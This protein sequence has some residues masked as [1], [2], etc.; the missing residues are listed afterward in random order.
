MIRTNGA[1][2]RFEPRA[3][4]E[5]P[6][7]L[8]RRL[9]GGRPKIVGIIQARTGSTRLPGKILLPILGRPV[10]S[11]MLERVAA[12]REL[13]E[14]VVA[15]TSLAEDEPIR[16]LAADLGVLCLS[17]HPTDLLDRHLKVARARSADALVK[18][19]S[20]CPL[21]DPR[22]I[23]LVVGHFRR[24][25]PRLA[26]V[27]NLHPPT[28]PDGND[29]EVLRVDVLEEAWCL[30]TRTFQREHTT[31]F[32]WDQPERFALGNVSS[33]TGHD[34]SATHRLT[35]DYQG[36]FQL[37][38]EVFTALYRPTRPAFSAEEIVAHLD[39]HPEVRALN[40][41]HL[42]SSWIS[43]HT[44]ELNTLHPGDGAPSPQVRTP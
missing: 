10:L 26:F 40:A 44:A 27:S 1:H 17:G 18:I 5:V 11:W 33:P 32:I 35:L 4:Q 20:D 14:V 28:W 9:D 23:D 29:V 41:R 39:A 7:P 34:F 37:I 15:T 2:P 30:A 24:N 3:A 38:A 31:P 12:A 43:A 25:Y 21:I 42:G 8:P 19:P 16:A 36:D 22:A 6:E 13:D